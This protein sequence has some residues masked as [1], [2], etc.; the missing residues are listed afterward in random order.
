MPRK[1]PKPDN[2]AQSKRFIKTA[3]KVE[4]DD[5]GALERVLKSISQSPK[6]G[7]LA[8]PVSAEVKNIRK[9]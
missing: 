8:A 9:K 2:L 3:K 1:T 6:R 7:V 5:A 4:A